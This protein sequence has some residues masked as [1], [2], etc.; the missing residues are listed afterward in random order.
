[1]KLTL[2]DLL[3]TTRRA[4][5]CLVIE[6]CHLMTMIEDC[7]QRHDDPLRKAH[8]YSPH[9][10]S[11]LLTRYLIISNHL[12]QLT[13]SCT[14]DSQP[15]PSFALSQIHYLF[16][17]T[18]GP[19]G[20]IIHCGL[21][22]SPPPACFSSPTINLNHKTYTVASIDHRR[23]LR[24]STYKLHIDIHHAFQVQGRAP[25]REAQG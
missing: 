16:K 9:D 13:N 3:A 1:M 24:N 10:D 15:L 6:A 14:V 4:D 25:L 23:R 17:R 19:L 11:E 5:S 18:A 7:R 12:L 22:R 21:I 20:L 8:Q 2:E